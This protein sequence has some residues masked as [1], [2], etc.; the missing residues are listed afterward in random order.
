LLKGQNWND[1]QPREEVDPESVELINNGACGA[2]VHGLEDEL[3]A[4]R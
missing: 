3:M 1:D 4:V 2:F